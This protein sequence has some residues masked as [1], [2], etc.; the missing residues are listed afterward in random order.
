MRCSAS[1][2]TSTPAFTKISWV[3][4]YQLNIQVRPRVVTPE[5]VCQHEMEH[6]TNSSRLLPLFLS[7]RP[8]G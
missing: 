8:L 2:F 4:V 7:M 5:E 3:T 6:K 1:Y